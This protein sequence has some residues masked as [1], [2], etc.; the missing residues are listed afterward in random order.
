MYAPPVRSL[1]FALTGAAAFACSARPEAQL[2]ELPGGSFPSFVA[3]RQAADR[4][5]AMAASSSAAVFAPELHSGERLWLSTYGEELSRLGLSPG[6]IDGVAPK[7]QRACS[8]LH[9]SQSYRASGDPLQ[10]EPV[11][12][13]EVPEALWS[14]LVPDP[15]RCRT[16]C[17]TMSVRALSLNSSA[18]LR[19]IVSYQGR[20][21]VAAS[22]GVL[23]RVDVDRER[24]ELFCTGLPEMDAGALLDDRLYLGL[25]DLVAVD[26]ASTTPGGPCAIVERERWPGGALIRSLLATHEDGSERLF[27]TT[28]T[29]AVLERRGGSWRT[30]AELA[31]LPADVESG[32]NVGGLT[33]LED[34]SV[35]AVVGGGEL[36]RYS[37]QREVSVERPEVDHKPQRIRALA[38]GGALGVVLAADDVGLIVQGPSGWRRLVEGGQPWSLPS[39]LIRVGE[40]FVF[41]AFVAALVPVYPGFGECPAATSVG[42]G[43]PQAAV[44]LGPDRAVFLENRPDSHEGEQSRVF[45][46]DWAPSCGGLP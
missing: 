31:L 17:G 41:G 46:L 43:A 13:T 22:D 15:E 39:V 8:L 27:V 6:L 4:F 26:L 9:P 36:L 19:V 5:T 7:C 32:T 14:R 28:S 34:R 30:L 12:I 18:E 11:P 44:A 21:L 2:L 25:E 29:G 10:W 45:V 23:L 24:A 38:D 42:L 1:A 33:I 37:Q 20:L 35:V 16:P 40:R 3:S